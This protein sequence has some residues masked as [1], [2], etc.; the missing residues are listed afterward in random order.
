[1]TKIYTNQLELEKDNPDKAI[2]SVSLFNRLVKRSKIPGEWHYNGNVIEYFVKPEPGK[3]YISTSELYNLRK[4]GA[5]Y[6]DLGQLLGCTKQGAYDKFIDLRPGDI[7]KVSRVKLQSI[8]QKLT[9][10][11]LITSKSDL[12]LDKISENLVCLICDIQRSSL[13]YRLRKLRIY[14]EVYIPTNWKDSLEELPIDYLS[15]LSDREAMSIVKLYKK[16]IIDSFSKKTNK[17]E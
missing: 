12:Y 5:S 2:V 8:N 6:K 16:G 13:H 3:T 7:H 10:K 9:N 11:T 17:G 4:Q 15:T 1:M 14:N